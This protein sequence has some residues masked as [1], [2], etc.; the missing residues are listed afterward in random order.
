MITIRCSK[1]GKHV[2]SFEYPDIYNINTA[3]QRARRMLG[4]LINNP[5][6]L[7]WKYSAMQVIQDNT[8]YFLI[9][10]NCPS[11]SNGY[12]ISG[13]K[14]IK[15]ALCRR[16]ES[17]F[18]VDM[19]NKYKGIKYNGIFEVQIKVYF[20]SYASDID[21]CTKILLDCLQKY[22]VIKNDNK[23]IRI[24]DFEKYVDRKNPRVEM[25]LITNPEYTPVNPLP[26]GW[27]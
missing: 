1:K 27:S 10:G 7:G 26:R 6:P 14:L 22:D 2:F 20:S 19:D 16:F 9:K 15:T 21:G 17:Q 4:E 24:R 23:C 25:K 18:S 12:R 13:N 5:K 11:K 8:M 3:K